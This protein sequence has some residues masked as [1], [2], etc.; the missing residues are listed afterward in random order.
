MPVAY[1]HVLLG[2]P[3]SKRRGWVLSNAAR[4]AQ[5]AAHQD[6]ERALSPCAGLSAQHITR[7]RCAPGEAGLPGEVSH[8]QSQQPH[9]T[10]GRGGPAPSGS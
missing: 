5:R 1:L 4:A 6:A 3:E 9:G 10:A 8:L 2:D 7:P